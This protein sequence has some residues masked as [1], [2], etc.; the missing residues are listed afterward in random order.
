MTNYE[1]DDNVFPLAY[2][3]TIRT[4]GTW[5]HGDSRGSVDRHDKNV[6]GTPRI[7]P[8]RALA[9]VMEEEMKGPPFTLNMAQRLVVD[10]EIKAVCEKR[11]YRLRALNVRT[12][13]GHSV[14]SAEIKPELIINAFK[15]N[16]TR[17]LREQ[18]LVS[19]DT[20]VWSRGKSRRYLW[21]PRS[22]GLAIDY[23][24]NQQG[25]NLIDFETWLK[26][27]GESLDDDE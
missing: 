17:A 12:N 20:Q 15:A 2:L 4:F 1:W 18:G 3:I 22:V 26:M 10:S 24:L 6:Y 8:N 16:S 27:K 25:E 19:R 11:N 13:H 9:R 23:T 21:K 5:L 7:E 14:V